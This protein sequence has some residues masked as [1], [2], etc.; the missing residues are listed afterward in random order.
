MADEHC[1]GSV[2][3]EQ[4]KYI[5]A[6][7]CFEHVLE[8][9]RDLLGPQ[10][11]ETLKTLQSLANAHA[12]LDHLDEALRI[13]DQL[14]AEY[15]TQGPEGLLKL[16]T[17]S[18]NKAAILK[19][20]GRKDEA[21]ELLNQTLE[22]AEQEPTMGPNHIDTMSIVFNIGMILSSQN[23]YDQAK[24]NFL[25]TI[26][27]YENHFGPSHPKVLNSKRA[28]AA[29]MGTN[30][31]YD[32][33]TVLFESVLP[34]F[35]K[36]LGWEH[37]D[38]LA[39]AQNLALFYWVH[40]NNL[41]KAID[42][43]K[44]CLHYHTLILGDNNEFSLQNMQN[45]GSIYW[46]MKNFSESSHLLEHVFQMRKESVG[47]KD[48]RIFDISCWL[49]DIHREA[50]E[51][52]KVLLTTRR[53]YEGMVEKLGPSHEKTVLLQY[54][55]G[56][57]YLDLGENENALHHFVGFLDNTEPHN[58]LFASVQNMVEILKERISQET[59]A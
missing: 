42:L 58:E 14:I 12:N 3:Y 40:E 51:L 49:I 28:L 23:C 56:V 44:K 9:Q 20:L 15:K 46:E 11:L 7:E 5:E 22:L 8:K 1:Y 43:Y 35:E 52:E 33:A 57:A 59:R 10:H 6:V 47:W 54:N 39:V 31:K 45:I 50:G 26:S 53:L 27:C 13:C 17:I 4:G 18:S 24:S 25:R 19:N 41:P 16:L 21:L 34:Q 55:L 30:R 32:E 38:T 36:S 29:M 2:L 48:D 37:L